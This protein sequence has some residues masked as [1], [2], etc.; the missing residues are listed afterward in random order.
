[1]KHFFRAMLCLTVAASFLFTACKKDDQPVPQVPQPEQYFTIK[2]KASIT[3]G[4]IVYD[5]IPGDFTITSWDKNGIKQ[6]KD[7]LM[8]A[9]THQVSLPASHL[10]YAIRLSK[11]GK[12]YE[13]PLPK[14]EVINGKLYTVGGTKAAKKLLS[15]F[16]YSFQEGTFQLQRK[17]TYAYDQQGRLDKISYSYH[18]PGTNDPLPTLAS[19]DQLIYNDNRLDQI[20]T[21]DKLEGT[22]DVIGFS[23]FYYNQQGRVEAVQYK[24]RE[25]FIMY[26]NTYAQQ[27][28]L[29]LLTMNALTEDH[30]PSG[31]RIDLK[32]SNGNRVEET[33]IVPATPVSTR[34]Y[35]FDDAIN[36][37]IHLK[38]HQLYFK[39]QSK[40]NV[41][42]EKLDGTLFLKTEY[43]YDGDGYPTEMIKKEFHPLSGEYR[44]VLKTIYS[45]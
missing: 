3:V 38:W 17:Q 36:P 37:Y 22:N 27:D 10:R 33:T 5:S 25:N 40:N 11:W 15:E 24:Y 39:D 23:R 45:Y 26:R 32:F 13:L 8:P 42:A 35:G 1:M 43:Q 4:D 34:S 12:E 31:S 29:E 6:E 7:T 30:N 14:N 18:N 41:V 19:V 21:V 9:G 2:V 28:G 16:T 20:E 44:P